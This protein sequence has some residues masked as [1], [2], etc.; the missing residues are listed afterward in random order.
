[1]TVLLVRH[2]PV[3]KRWAR[4]CYGA[5]DVPLTRTWRATMGPVVAQLRA[6]RIGLIVHSD[7][8]RTR[9]PAEMIARTLGVPLIA[10]PDWRERDFGAW[11][12]RSWHAIWRETGNAMDGMIH[13]PAHF[14]PG[15]DSETTF[16]LR[17]RVML[18]YRRLSGA[19]VA[20]VTHGGPIA[21]LRGSLCGAEVRLW[22]SFISPC[23]AISRVGDG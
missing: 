12:G 2:P 21:A 13:A 4:R 18:A 15:G 6:T 16:E 23:G 19:S 20:V 10:D 3:A 14:R 8:I 5:S 22:P 17:D 1:M 9:L 7:L 11:E